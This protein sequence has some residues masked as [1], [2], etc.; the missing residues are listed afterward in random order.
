MG[1]DYNRT[2]R[3]SDLIQ[4]ELSFLIQQKMN[5]PRVGMVTLSEVVVSRDLKHAKVYVNVLKEENSRNVIETLNHAAGFLRQGLAKRVQLR[6]TPALAFYYDD[7][8]NKANKIDKLI[9]DALSND[10]SD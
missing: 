10:S 2:E 6:S 8:L 5:D 7:T 4:R 9:D 3:V 1:K